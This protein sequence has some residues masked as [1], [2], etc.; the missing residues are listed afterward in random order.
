MSET[1]KRGAALYALSLLG[2]V[3]MIYTNSDD[4]SRTTVT[5]S[6]LGGLFGCFTLFALSTGSEA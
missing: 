2:V 6:Q 4:W 5:L 1:P 3:A